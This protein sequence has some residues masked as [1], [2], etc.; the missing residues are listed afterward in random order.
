MPLRRKLNK[1]IKNI[2]TQIMKRKKH[3]IILEWKK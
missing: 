1:M 2:K 3:L